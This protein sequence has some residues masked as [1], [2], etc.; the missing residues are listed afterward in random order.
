MSA[1]LLVARNLAAAFLAGVWSLEGLVRRGALACGL[2]E[3]RLR[4]LARRVL[5]AFGDH[6]ERVDEASLAQFIHADNG[7][8]RAWG[9][10]RRPQRVPLRRIYRTVPVM[11]AAPGVLAALH[12]PALTTSAV[13]AGWL[14]I[15]LPQLDWFADRHGGEAHA[16]LGPLRHYTYR[17]MKQTSGKMRLL[18]RPKQRLKTLQRKILHEILDV[19]PP[20]EAVHGYRRG[21]SVATYVASH[22]GRRIVLHFDLRDFFPSVRRSRVHALFTTVG[23]P[24][25]VARILTGLCTNVVPTDVLSSAPRQSD[26]AQSERM[27]RWFC[28]PHLPQGAPTSPALANLCVY[29]LDCRLAELARAV[30]AT[31]TRYADDLT[32]SGE[33]ELERSARR[34]QVE[35]CRI[36][37]EEGF[38]V[39]TRKSRFMRQGVRQQVAGIVLN[40]HPNIRR[41]EYERLKAI[42]HNCLRHG[43]ETQNRDGQADFKAHLVGRIAYVSMLNAARGR[44]LRA[45]FDNIQWSS[46]SS[47]LE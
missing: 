9:D 44:R 5:A 7:F 13:L 45:A 35:V 11:S 4:P 12:I 19:I 33:V 10:P 47:P 18:E 32:F 31:Y 29:R 39:H 22:A 36:A 15:S 28:S 2:R 21:R 41:D 24:A 8:M 27:R 16:P 3:R 42:L 20:H 6:A 23:Y 14:G 43:P 38:E 17:W 30:G 26:P 25:V 1:K 46:P 34:F 37:L 40:A